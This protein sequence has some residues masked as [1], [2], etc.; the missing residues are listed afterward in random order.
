MYISSRNSLWSN[1]RG[2]CGLDTLQDL[3]CK[4]WLLCHR[5]DCGFII[6][7]LGGLELHHPKSL[8]E[9]PHHLE[10]CVKWRIKKSQKVDK[11]WWQ[12]HYSW[13]LHIDKNLYYR[14]RLN[15]VY[16]RKR[17]NGVH[18]VSHLKP[19][20]APS[21]SKRPRLKLEICPAETN[22]GCSLNILLITSLH[23]YILKHPLRVAFLSLKN[24]PHTAVRHSPRNPQG[25]SVPKAHL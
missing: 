11:K 8:V 16:N 12:V 9:G 3:V 15:S 10:R 1:W 2:W 23:T 25:S 21:H 20:I 17:M 5:S 19:S 7:I 4:T 6:G 13:K 24:Y 22:A 14:K 18:S